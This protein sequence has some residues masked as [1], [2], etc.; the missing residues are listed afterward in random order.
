M[1]EEFPHELGDCIVCI[2]DVKVDT[3]YSY[4]FNATL[5]GK[6][7]QECLGSNP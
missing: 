7:D 5:L 3:H 1:V 2:V 6:S 4:R